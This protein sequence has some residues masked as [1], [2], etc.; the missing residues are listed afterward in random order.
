MACGCHEDQ[1][2]SLIIIF[3]ILL[4]QFFWENAIYC[5]ISCVSIEVNQILENCPFTEP[6]SDMK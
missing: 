2:L 3:G 6:N 4:S 5:T 1:I